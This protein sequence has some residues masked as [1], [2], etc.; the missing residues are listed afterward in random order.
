MVAGTAPFGR[1][2]AV[3]GPF[4]RT[5]PCHHSGIQ[6]ERDAIDRYLANHPVVQ[7]V[8]DALIGALGKFIEESHDGFEI[9]HAL[10]A[11]QPF[12]D[13]VMPGD[14]TVLETIGATPNRE[15]ELGD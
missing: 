1:V 3:C 12:Q 6:I 13:R 10:E 14:F 5:I 7:R 2:L 11:K 9:G 15:R 8:H 4:L